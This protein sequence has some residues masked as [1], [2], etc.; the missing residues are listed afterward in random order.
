MSKGSAK[1]Q[2]TAFGGKLKSDLMDWPREEIG[3]DIYLI[4][5]ME[6]PSFVTEQN[7]SIKVYERSTRRGRFEFSGGY[8]MSKETPAIYKL[9][10]VQS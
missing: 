2:L 4:L 8:G 10:E 7:S 3:R 5:D 9:V 6:M 1:V